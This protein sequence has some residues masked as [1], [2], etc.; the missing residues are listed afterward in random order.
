M[1]IISILMLLIYLVIAFMTIL[2]MRSKV[3]DLARWIS[4][5]LFLFSLFTFAFTLD[6]IDFWLIIAISLC[7]VL[8]I[9]ITAFKDS[10]GDKNNLFIIHAFT[11]TMAL[12]LIIMLITF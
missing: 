1:I 8:S 6:G 3:F 7:L 9:E 10:K 2:N 5:L 4:G 11:L 12:V